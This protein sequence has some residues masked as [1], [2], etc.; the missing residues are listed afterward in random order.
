MNSSCAVLITLFEIAEATAP[1][2]KTDDKDDVLGYHYQIY[3]ENK[4][5]ETIEVF[6]HDG[7]KIAS[8]QKG[9]IKKIN[10]E[11]RNSIYIIGRNSQ[12]QYLSIICD[13]HQATIII[14][15]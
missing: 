14:N 11:K 13:V 12:K 7:R 6:Y 2:W 15:K 8:I 1:Y 3:I 5:D 10:V 4:T 9:K